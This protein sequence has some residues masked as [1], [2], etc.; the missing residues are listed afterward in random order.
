MNFS[1]IVMAIAFLVGQQG[2]APV[3]PNGTAP[4]GS[5]QNGKRIYV[6]YGCFQCH[7]Y[8]AQGGGPAGPRLAPRPLAFT[9]FSRAVRQPVNQMP[10]YTGKVLSDQ[11]L[12]DI[13]AFLQSVPA[14]PPL[15]S[16][17]LLND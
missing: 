6:S 3:S 4:A 8:E 7:G 5:V 1:I 12:A 17:P 15:E 9:A 2:P 16:I 14:P 13:Y 11:E 10:P